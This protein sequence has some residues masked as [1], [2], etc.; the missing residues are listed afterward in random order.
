VTVRSPAPAIQIYTKEW[1]GFC[2][3]ATRLF[4]GL[5]LAFDEIPVDRDPDLRWR[6]AAEAGNWPTV[7]MI[8]INGRFIGGFTEAADLHRR[9]RL[10]PM[11]RNRTAAGND[12]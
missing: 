12:S 3:A 2:H 7:P 9:G 4:N 11:C 5:G 8:F 1:C 10:L 6:V